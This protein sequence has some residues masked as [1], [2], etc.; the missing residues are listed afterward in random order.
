MAISLTLNEKDVQINKAPTGRNI[1]RMGV[2]S[3]RAK[4][5]LKIHI[6]ILTKFTKN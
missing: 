5:I 1:P 2:T 6:K 3:A 4:I